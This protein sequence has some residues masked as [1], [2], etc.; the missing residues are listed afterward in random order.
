M[1]RQRNLVF[2]QVSEDSRKWEENRMVS[3]GIARSRQTN[4]QEL[5][6]DS[7]ARVILSVHNTTP[8][9][10]KGKAAYTNQQGEVLTV[11]DANADIARLARKGSQSLLDVREQ[12]SRIRST[13]EL[14]GVTDEEEPEE[15]TGGYAEAMNKLSDTPQST[16][17]KQKSLSEQRHQLP[18]TACKSD[19]IRMV[20]ENQV[21]VIK[22]ETG[23]GKSTQLPQFFLEEGFGQIGDTTLLIGCTQPRRM[24]AV[25]VARRVAA[26]REVEVGKE[27]GYAIRFEDVTSDSTRIKFMTDGI[28]LRESLRDEMLSDYSV[29]IMDEAHERSLNTDVLFGL[30]KR[31]LS[32]RMDLRVIITSATLDSD[33][34]AAFFGN[35]PVFSVPGRTFPVEILHTKAMVDDYVDAVVKQTVAVHMSSPLPGDILVFMTGQEDIDAVC[36]LVEEKIKEKKGKPAVVM[37]LYSQLSADRQS[38]IFEPAREGERKIVVSTNLAETSLTVDGI[39]YVID[40]GFFKCKIYN[41]T[42]GMDSLLVTPISRAQADQRSGRAGRTGPGQ[43]YRLYTERCYKEEMLEGAI[44]EIQRTNLANVVL[45][46]KS[47]GIDDLLEFEFMDPPPQQTLL[48][49]MF[50]L[51]L[52]GALNNGGQLSLLGR[53]LAEFP[54]DPTLSKMIVSSIDFECSEEIVTIVSS[55]SVPSIFNRPRNEEEKGRYGT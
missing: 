24:A 15:Q 46:L 6:E 30:L 33:R 7:D 8:P 48:N 32:V 53:Q 25:S 49:S 9:F 50:Q 13:K 47:L 36:L 35:A 23:S 34:F 52:L 21:V 55:L 40:S 44:P 41:P 10:L 38:R 29:I 11:R 45:L 18:I 22:G 27:V 54:L 19:L 14:L 17:S 1:E 31:V 20:R 26:E 37:P 39:K 51:W 28:L 5:D 4:P 3:T 16:W 2:S 42:I 43:C 12:K